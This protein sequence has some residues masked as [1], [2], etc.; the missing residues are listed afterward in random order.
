MSNYLNYQFYA[1]FEK[2]KLNQIYLKHLKGKDGIRSEKDLLIVP[3]KCFWLADAMEQSG[4]Y[5]KQEVQSCASYSACLLEHRAYD[6]RLSHSL[7][8]PSPGSATNSFEQSKQ[9]TYHNL[10]QIEDTFK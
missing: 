4:E 1:R 7:Y 8:L 5:S 6:L 2:S 3:S 10:D 9:L